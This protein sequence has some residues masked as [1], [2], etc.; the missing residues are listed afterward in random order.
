MQVIYINDIDMKPY[1]VEMEEGRDTLSFLQEMVEGLIESVSLDSK[2]DLWLNEEGLFR[3]DFFHNEFASFLAQGTHLRGPAVMTGIDAGRTV[4]IDIDFIMMT[5]LVSDS[6]VYT[7]SEVVAI[8]QAQL[9]EMR[10]KG[11]PV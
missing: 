7:A 6:N 1:I 5:S 2:T 11:V 10:A 3:D 9:Q 4:G 8:R